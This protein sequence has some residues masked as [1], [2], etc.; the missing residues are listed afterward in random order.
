M[1]LDLVFCRL[2]TWE[3]TAKLTKVCDEK[4]YNER[5]SSVTLSASDKDSEGQNTYDIP[6]DNDEEEDT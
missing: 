4:K 6:Y 1:L 5:D 2:P 3:P